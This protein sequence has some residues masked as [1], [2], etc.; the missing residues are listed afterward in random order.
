MSEI[1]L[2]MKH[3]HRSA[4]GRTGRS[5]LVVLIAVAVVVGGLGVVVWR[6]AD[7]VSGWFAEPENYSGQGSGSVRVEVVQGD[8]AATI[9]ATLEDAGVVASAE[10]FTDAAAA[11][12]RSMSIQPG[13]YEMNEE[14]SAAAALD[15]LVEGKA[16]IDDDVTVPEGFTV[17]E[18]LDRLA[19]E[20][21]LSARQLSEAA[22]DTDQLAL[23]PWSGDDVE[24]YLFPST[25]TIGPGV[26]A[27]DAL[28]QMVA[29]FRGVSE[30]LSLEAGAQQLGISPRE[31]VIV[32]SLIEA[33]ASRPQDLGKVA[34]VIYN[35]LDAGMMLQLDSTVKFAEGSSDSIYTTE[36]ERSNPS[37]YNTYQWK[38]L[39]PTAINSPGARALRAALH[40]TSGNW[41]YFVT[42]DLD[43]GRTLFA[44]TFRQHKRYVAKL[45]AYCR[46]S[47][48]C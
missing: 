48:L 44:D 45:T 11:D 23:P 40:P 33:E 20:T 36:Q 39:P 43:T 27:V 18:T 47:D 24:G 46:E 42:V 6:G 31:V 28:G 32:A 17:Q 34:Q 37:R 13:R 25:Y 4:K 2:R 21:D 12:P 9:G 7:M 14:M 5:C 8:S 26:S 30:E 19:D 15:L 1:D 41:M 29:E 22:R 16:L 10:A 38:G 35:R 3:P